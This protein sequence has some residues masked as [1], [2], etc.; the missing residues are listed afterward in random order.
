M[1]WWF[2]AITHASWLAWVRLPAGGA[3]IQGLAAFMGNIDLAYATFVAFGL[4]LAPTTCP[5]PT[6]TLGRA[7]RESPWAER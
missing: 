3:N 2:L 7:A 6:L 5:A 4:Y 1:C